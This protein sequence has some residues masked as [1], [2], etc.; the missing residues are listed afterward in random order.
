MFGWPG[1]GERLPAGRQGSVRLAESETRK[2]VVI[3]ESKR[4]AA[5]ITNAAV[6]GDAGA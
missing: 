1:G 6:I 3:L 2:E 5:L 4:S